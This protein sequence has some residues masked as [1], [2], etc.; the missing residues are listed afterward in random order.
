MSKYQTFTM[1]T[2]PRKDINT[3]SYNPR[4]I[5]DDNRKR[6]QQ[7]IQEN[8]LVEPLVWN[9][10]TGNLVSG[11][12]R[13]AI[14]DKLERSQDYDLDVAVIDV[15]E[16]QE[17]RL[18]V[19]LNNQSM[20][21]VFDLDML[22]ELAQEFEGGLSE[23]GFSDLDIEFMYGA[24]DRFQ[25]LLPDTPAVEAT[26]ADIQEI[27]ANREAMGEKYAKE[28]SAD[29]YFIVV[30]SSQEEKTEFL[31]SLSV[32]PYERYITIAQLRRMN[33]NRS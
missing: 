5:D 13:L 32:S 16:Q 30:C 20:M 29:F 9:Q 12:Q 23:L 33:R 21:G 2:I 17:K 4:Q 19:Q 26:K 25:D 1:R 22:G 28:Q 11:H 7:G 31:Q 18:N 14:L 24:N 27:K 3:A 6:L 10:R 15:D 8:G